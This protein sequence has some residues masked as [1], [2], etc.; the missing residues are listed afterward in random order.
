MPGTHLRADFITKCLGAVKKD[1]MFVLKLG[2][3]DNLAVT[4]LSRVD[5]Q[6]DKGRLSR[7]HSDLTCPIISLE[8]RVP[9][10]C[11]AQLSVPNRLSWATRHE[12][13]F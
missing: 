6:F 12:R 2:V 5:E 3:G 11:D 9:H 4:P 7:I 1:R 10:M 8:F 13:L